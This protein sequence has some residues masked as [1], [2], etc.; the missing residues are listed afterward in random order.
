MIHFDQPGSHAAWC[1]THYV[2]QVAEQRQA[3]A[4]HGG[5]HKD[6]SDIS[7][8]SVHAPSLSE[9]LHT[10]STR[11]DRL[12]DAL[13]DVGS[14]F[15]ASD[16]SSRDDMQHGH[17]ED[18]SMLNGH[19]VDVDG[20]RLAR[21]Q[22]ASGSQNVLPI[23]Q[24]AFEEACVKYNAIKQQGVQVHM[25]ASFVEIYQDSIRDLLANRH[26]TVL[27]FRDPD[28]KQDVILVG[29]QEVEVGSPLTA[30]SDIAYAY[31]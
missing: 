27:T 28:P 17:S 9:P 20:S 22:D 15:L 12:N 31:S 7:C 26:D 18:Q 29:L 23:V 5:D 21:L 10:P 6:N 1:D 24:K 2:L 4:M 8:Q 11:V 16:S 3:R 14:S 25:Y 19:H 13:G 30:S